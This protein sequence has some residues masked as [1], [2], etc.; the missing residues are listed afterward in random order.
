MPPRSHAAELNAT[1][2][3]NKRRRLLGAVHLEPPAFHVHTTPHA[4]IKI[5]VPSVKNMRILNRGAYRALAV[6]FGG[7]VVA[8]GTW[9]AETVF[10]RSSD[11]W[12]A[13][14]LELAQLVGLSSLLGLGLLTSLVV[15]GRLVGYRRRVERAREEELARLAEAALTD[16]LTGLGNHR[17]FHENVERELRRRARPGSSFSV[18][19]LDLDGLR[20]ARAP[21][22]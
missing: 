11:N 3:R 17:A 6:V 1:T 14:D 9:G 19:M 13:N 10:A 22:R 7:L 18:V 16:S 8:L 20:H 21:G 4:V 5:S 15:L 2:H 12:P